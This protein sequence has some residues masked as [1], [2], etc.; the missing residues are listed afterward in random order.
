M[1]HITLLH[2]EDDPDDAFF[3]ARALAKAQPR[4]EVRR[5][6]SGEQAL[7]Y[8]QGVGDYANRQAHPLPRLMVLDLKLPGLNGFEVLSWVR[9][10]VAL[11]GLP[12]IILSGSSLGTDQQRATQLGA[13]G[14]LTKH[15]DY[16]EVVQAAVQLLSSLAPLTALD[17]EASPA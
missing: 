17:S 4:W 5:V 2:V 13:S 10:Q 11:R 3:F 12:V 6:A 16:Q 14:Y 8:L 9:S 15:S 7:E 1:N